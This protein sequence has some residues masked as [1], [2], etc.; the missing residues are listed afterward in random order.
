MCAL[1]HTHIHTYTHTHIHTYILHTHVHAHAYTRNPVG[2][3]RHRHTHSRDWAAVAAITGCCSVCAT[4]ISAQLGL[5]CAPAA[6]WEKERASK[7]W[8][9]REMSSGWCWGGIGGG[10]RVGGAS[11]WKRS[12]GRSARESEGE[13][14]MGKSVRQ[15]V[16]GQ[17]ISCDVETWLKCVLEAYPESTLVQNKYCVLPCKS[18]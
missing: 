10:G 14:E 15:V 16:R 11:K 3:W 18:H 6:F 8:C 2:N 5:V 1:L 9:G 7:H 13:R 12:N 4:T 17:Q